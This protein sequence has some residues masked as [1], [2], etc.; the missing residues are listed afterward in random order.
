MNFEYIYAYLNE[1]EEGGQETISIDN[2]RAEMKKAENARSTPRKRSKS[3]SCME[4]VV[5]NVEDASK[6]MY[7]VQTTNAEIDRETR[8]LTNVQSIQSA[9]VTNRTKESDLAFLEVMLDI[10]DAPTV[11]IK[12]TLETI[13]SHWK[14]AY[15]LLLADEQNQIYLQRALEAEQLV[16]EHDELATRISTQMNKRIDEES[17]NA[18]LHDECNG[19]KQEVYNLKL[20]LMRL[21]KQA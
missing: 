17:R 14:G 8:L 16:R 1:C 18:M 20:E 2:I 11:T 12:K 10:E 3:V 19:L 5:A 6:A 7:L 9:F 4:D 21:K 13:L 15:Q